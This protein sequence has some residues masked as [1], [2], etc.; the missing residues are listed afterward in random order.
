MV[1]KSLNCLS[2]N[3]RS[4]IDVSRRTELTHIYCTQIVVDFAFIQDTHLR[5]TH[6]IVLDNYTIIRDE[7]SQ[8]VLVAFR[9]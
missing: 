6:R 4:L 5:R 1:R 3:V 2:F 8:R 7:R 9:K